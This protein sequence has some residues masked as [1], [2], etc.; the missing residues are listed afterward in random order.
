MPVFMSFDATTG[1]LS[2]NPT[3]KTEV[4]VYELEAVYTMA[5]DLTFNQAP[6]L[7]T[8]NV[9]RCVITA[10]SYDPAQVMTYQYTI[11]DPEKRLSVLPYH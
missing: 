4:G 5:L 1:I 8:V 3:L 9:E 11:G 10:F 6:S 7:I 2:V